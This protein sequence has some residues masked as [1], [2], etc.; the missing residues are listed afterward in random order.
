MDYV[1]S[2]RGISGLK[3]GCRMI[4]CMILSW[5][6]FIIV[7]IPYFQV[8]ELLPFPSPRCGTMVGARFNFCPNYKCNLHPA[9][10]NCKREVAETDKFC[11]YCG[12]DLEPAKTSEPRELPSVST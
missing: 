9:C 1:Y 5:L 8:R 12:T 7:F 3:V 11:A 6:F 2:E 4:L 10:P